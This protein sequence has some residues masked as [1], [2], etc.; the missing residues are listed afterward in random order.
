MASSRVN[1]N[2]E[3][4]GSYGNNNKEKFLLRKSSASKSKESILIET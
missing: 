2:D 1:R 4:N 3:E